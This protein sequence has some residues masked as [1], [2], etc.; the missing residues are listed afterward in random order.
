VCEFEREL[1][2]E[3]VCVTVTKREREKVCVSECDRVRE[4][5]GERDCMSDS[6]RL[7]LRLSLK[8][9]QK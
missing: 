3:S 7:C 8:S 4:R 2:N 5:N 9:I 1:R 6:K